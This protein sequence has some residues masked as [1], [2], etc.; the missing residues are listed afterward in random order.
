[1]R[2]K[3]DINAYFLEYY[4]KNKEK[5]KEQAR[6][7]Y[8]NNKEEIIKRTGAYARKRKYNLTQD[9]ILDIFNSQNGLCSICETKMDFTSRHTHVDHCHTT[10]KIRG[11][12]CSAC[13]CGLGHFKDNKLLL[14]RSISYLE[15]HEENST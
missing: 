4:D 6:R 2:T 3:E 8:E 13:N 10:G 12:L 15:K 5:V 7:Y 14:Q 9:Q 11:L 1:M